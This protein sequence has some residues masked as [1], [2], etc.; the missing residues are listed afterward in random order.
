MP[1]PPERL[2]RFLLGCLLTAPLAGAAAQSDAGVLQLRQGA[3]E[4][5]R[6]SFRRSPT[7]FEQEA[8]IALLNLRVSS[9]AVRGAGGRLE[10]F[11]LT[12]SNAAGDTSRATYHVLPQGDSMRVT[13]RLRANAADHTVPAGFDL[14]LPPQSMASFAELVTLAHGRDTTFRLLV[15]GPDTIMPA[16]VHFAGD[17]FHVAFASLDMPGV[18]AGDRVLAID[19]PAQRVQVSRAAW[20]DSL[21]PLTG[22]RRPAPDYSAPAGAPYT[23]TE[24]RVPVATARDS[25]SLGCTLTRPTAASRAVPAIVTITGSG[26]QPRDEELWPLVQGYRLFGAIA[27]RVGRE[28]IATLRCDDRSAGTSGGRADSATTADLAEDTRAQVNWLRKEQGVDPERIALVGHSEGGI[29]G[30]LLAAQ[31]RRLAALVILAGP[32][33]SGVEVL[34]DQA[35]WPIQTAPG[36]TAETRRARLAEA[37]A[38]IRADSFPAIPWMRWF[39][40]YDPIRA[41]R[42]VRQP[43]LILQ[44]ALDRQVSAGQADTLGAAVRSG[45]NADVTVRIFPRLNH[46][47][48]VSE[49]DGS[50]AEYPSLKDVAIPAPVLDTLALWLKARLHPGR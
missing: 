50:P 32:S 11:D 42:L 29:I 6:E 44:G 7:R 35:R 20:P 16:S 8:T 14:V 9:V 5:G 25:F 48:L 43:T 28:G 23:A 30:P 46:L 4:V 31:D 22:L 39:M 19:V 2:G 27:D 15:A 10:R 38:A 3:V 49:T 34:V 41:A 37:E 47:F 1:R 33:K 45:G 36:L 12:I 17:S 21:P 26:L 24:V 18:R 13:G 40:H